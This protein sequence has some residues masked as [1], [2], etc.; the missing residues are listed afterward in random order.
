MSPRRRLLK[1]RRAWRAHE[2]ERAWRSRMAT[3]LALVLVTQGNCAVPDNGWDAAE[4]AYASARNNL[5]A[6]AA[7]ETVLW[8]CEECPVAGECA[9]RAKIDRYT[10]LAAGSAWIRGKEYNPTRTIN[11]PRAKNTAA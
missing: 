11:N 9:Q 10:G 4:A 7:A 6:A 3:D 1:N 5:A 2:R 8:R